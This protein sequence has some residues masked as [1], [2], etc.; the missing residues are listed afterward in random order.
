MA[1]RYPQSITH[2]IQ[3]HFSVTFAAIVGSLPP[4][5]Q[6][7]YARDFRLAD[8]AFQT[9]QLAATSVAREACWQH[10]MSYVAPMGFDPYLKSTT[11]EQRI[12]YLTGFAQRIRT[13]YYGR[14]RQ[15]Q[16]ATVTGVITAVGKTI[17]MVIGNNPT[18]L[19]GSK[20]FLPALQANS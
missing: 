9:G 16:A 11:F 1:V 15:V 5:L 17:S 7:S 18:K 3:F 14:G 10:W 12:R 19:L 2:I 6:D 4:E 13:G 20:L 8:G